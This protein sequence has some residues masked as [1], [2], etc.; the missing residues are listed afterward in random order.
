[1]PRKQALS[2]ET[3]AAEN[4]LAIL[5]KAI[6]SKNDANALAAAKA[7][8]DCSTGSCEYWSLSDRIDRL[9]QRLRRCE[10]K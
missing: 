7:I 8:L 10:N 4:A 3:R 5:Q 1:M 6:D 2:I 9:E